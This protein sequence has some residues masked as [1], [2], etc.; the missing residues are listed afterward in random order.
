M[1]PQIYDATTRSDYNSFP[2]AEMFTK[3]Q[4]VPQE[5]SQE[6]RKETPQENSD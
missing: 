2:E 5:V 3:Q 4:E 6:I 1:K